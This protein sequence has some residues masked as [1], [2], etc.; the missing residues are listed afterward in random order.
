MCYQ[1]IHK[2]RPRDNKIIFFHK[3]ID[4]RK[5]DHFLNTKM[6]ELPF[7]RLALGVG[8]RIDPSKISML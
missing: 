2:N 4:T 8:Q 3:A 1:F 6:Q 5:I 7:V